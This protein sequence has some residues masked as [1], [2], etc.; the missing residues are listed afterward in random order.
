MQCVNLDNLRFIFTVRVGPFV[1]NGTASSN[2]LARLLRCHSVRL[3][4]DG[5]LRV[6]FETGYDGRLV[7]GSFVFVPND[8]SVAFWISRRLGIINRHRSVD[9]SPPMWDKPPSS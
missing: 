7:F 3:D 5:V 8:F 1:E 6:R 4:V 9:D 2:S